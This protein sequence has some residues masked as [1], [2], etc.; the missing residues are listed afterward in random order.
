MSNNLLSN[1]GHEYR[2]LI[3]GKLVESENGATFDNINPANEEVMGL[4]ANG[5]AKDFDKAIQAARNAFDQSD[6]STNHALRKTCIVQLHQAIMSE[7]EAFRS[8]L[9]EEVGCPVSLTHSAQLEW[10]IADGLLWP[11]EKIET[12]PWF[13]NSLENTSD[14][15]SP[16]YRWVWKEPIGVVSAVIPWNFPFEI[17]INKL[18]PILATGNTV[19]VKAASL[20]PWNALRIGRL[21]AEKTDIPP[22]V[23]NIVASNDHSVSEMLF[24]DPRIDMISFT[25]S[26][27]TGRLALEKS[28][29]TYK[30]TLMELGGKSA[31]ILLDD[32]DFTQAIPYSVFSANIHAGQGCALPTRLL[33][34]ESRFEEGIAIIKETY[35]S[36]LCGDPTDMNTTVGPLVSAKQRDKVLSYIEKGK[37]EG[38]KILVGGGVPKHLEKGYFVEPT[39]FINVKNHFAIAQEEIFGPVLSVITYKD[40]E[41]AIRIANESNYGLSGNIWS[42]SQERALNI[43]KKVRTGSLNINGGSFYGADSPYGGYKNSGIG[44]QGGIEGLET[45]LETKAVGSTF[46]IVNK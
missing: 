44:R 26:T 41:D 9:I 34:P 29:P 32:C 43:A 38:A 15:N 14:P 10:P 3:N 19:V 45:Y 1:S 16:M 4:V 6:W 36:I 25:G 27:A 2:M 42:A 11:A 33:I 40:D 31:S 20:T 22:G 37:A 30:R 7:I 35:K 24:T 12:Y 8:E 28:A 39:C 17:L 21:I 5:S 46:P 18:G 23:V 13:R